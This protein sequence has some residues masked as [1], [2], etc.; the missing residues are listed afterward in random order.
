VLLNIGVDVR[1]GAHE[2]IGMAL[3]GQSLC[4]GVGCGNPG[5]FDAVV[6]D[7][8]TE[9]QFII[10][11]CAGCSGEFSKARPPKAIQERPPYWQRKKRMSLA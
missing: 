4:N 5:T 1:V 9:L 7:Q 6:T 10:L 2:V 11:L 8:A 3:K